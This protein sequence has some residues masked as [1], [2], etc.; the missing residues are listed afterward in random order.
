MQT[1]A[2][3]IA[4]AIGRSLFIAERVSRP[5][6]VQLVP[7]ERRLSLAQFP[8]RLKRLAETYNLPREDREILR[9]NDVLSHNPLIAKS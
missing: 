7:T 6:V 1:E 9:R 2:R 3:A 5:N 4:A 8:T